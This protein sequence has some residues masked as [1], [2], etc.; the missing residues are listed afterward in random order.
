MGA[1]WLPWAGAYSLYISPAT[2]TI[3]QKASEILQR[4]AWTGRSRGRS[5][6]EAQNSKYS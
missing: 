6:S 5:G 2:G 3:K 4:G 1:P